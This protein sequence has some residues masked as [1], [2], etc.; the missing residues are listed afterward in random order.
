MQNV[1]SLL[2]ASLARH[3]QRPVQRIQRGGQWYSWT[4]AQFNQRWRTLAAALH[5]LGIQAG[6]RV[7]IWCPN[8][9]EWTLMDLS[10]MRLRALPVPVYTSSTAAQAAEVFEDAG[11][12][13]LAV[14]GARQVELARTVARQLGMRGLI[15]LDDEGEAGPG[16]VKLSTLLEGSPSEGSLEAVA[17]GVAAIQADDT[18]TLIYTSGT[19]GEPKGV[20]LSHTNLLHQCDT[21]D[22][23]FDVGPEDCSLSF[24]PLGHIFERVWSAYLLTRGAEIVSVEDITQVPAM[25]REVRPTVMVSVPR[26]FEKIRQTVLDKVSTAPPLRQRLF[27]FAMRAG[28]DMGRLKL[29]KGKASLGL[30]L[31]HALADRLVLSKLRDAVGGSKRLLVSGGA[32]LDRQVEDFFLAAGLPICQGYGLTE[33]SPIVSC[34]RPS[35]YR[36]GTVGRAVPGCEIR[37]ESAS[38][39]IQ[40]RGLNVFQG[41]WNKPGATALAFDGEWFRTGD[42]GVLDEDGYLCITDR[43]KDLIVTSQGKNIAP[44]RIEALLSR[45]LYIEQA[46]AVGDGRKCITALVVPVFEKLEAFA[47][48]HGLHFENRE[49]LLSLPEIVELVRRRIDAQSQEL[50]RHELVRRFTLLPELFNEAAGEITPTLK[51]RRRVIHQRYCD[52]IDSMYHALEE[53]TTVEAQPEG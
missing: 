24:L 8:R 23:F 29:A 44:Q 40:V 22:R 4:Y 45:D 52:L 49:H 1:I 38:G 51:L 17:Q 5:G 27:S 6:D 39:E 41:Y 33:T 35:E 18:V 28:M 42:V 20:M 21:V 9:P 25:L 31:R 19:T 2:E 15:L 12:C 16:E 43:I 34:N 3:A 48:E 32:A 13:W 53:S 50:A 47:R 14:G 7:G 11:A 30:K 10:L 26:L 36:A 37:L 46:A